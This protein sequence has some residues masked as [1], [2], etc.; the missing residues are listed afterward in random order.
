MTGWQFVNLYRV[1]EMEKVELVM[2]LTRAARS[3]V[4]DL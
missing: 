3:W 2:S 4:L 1:E